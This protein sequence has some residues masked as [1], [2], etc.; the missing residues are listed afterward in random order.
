MPLSAGQLRAI[1]ITERVASTFS[2]L[3]TLFVIGTFLASSAFHK[4]INRLV[5]WASWGNMIT[6]VA[7]LISRAGIRAGINSPLCQIQS[8]I[9]QM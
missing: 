3:G 5:F 7:T 9:I 1:E 4:P 8:F 6:S 2:L